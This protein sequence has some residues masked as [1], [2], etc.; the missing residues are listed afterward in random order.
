MVPGPP[1]SS[2]RRG[3][4]PCRFSLPGAPPCHARIFFLPAALSLQRTDPSLSPSAGSRRFS[5]SPWLPP[6]SPRPLLLPPSRPVSSSAAQLPV[7]ALLPVRTLLPLFS[8]LL[9]SSSGYASLLSAFLPA[10]SLLWP[11][12]LGSRSSP[13]S[14]TPISSLEPASRRAP[15][16]VLFPA[17][18]WKLRPAF[19]P[20]API[21]AR[22]GHLPLPSSTP[23][24][25]TKFAVCPYVA[26]CLDPSQVDLVMVLELSWIRHVVYLAAPASRIVTLFTPSTPSDAHLRSSPVSYF[27]QHHILRDA[28]RCRLSRFARPYHLQLSMFTVVHYA[29]PCDNHAIH[30]M[31]SRQKFEK[32]RCRRKQISM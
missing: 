16:H 23:F 7:R 13:S 5:P 28:L 8:S 11:W 10:L 22:Q 31:C 6:S 2:A 24:P 4:A 1:S 21:R 29:Q 27:S 25:A 19:V 15:P 18:P 9:S 30:G 17:R 20:I 14:A 32:I 3:I 26:C 12:I